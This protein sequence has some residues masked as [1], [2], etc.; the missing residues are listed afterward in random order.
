[1]KIT[2]LGIGFVLMSAP[3]FAAAQAGQLAH[4][5]EVRTRAAEAHA[6]ALKSGDRAAAVRAIA[7][8]RAADEAIYYDK[9]DAALAAEG[10]PKGDT[11]ASE[12]ALLN[13]KEAAQRAAES[14]DKAAIARADAELR[15][16]YHHDWEVRHPGKPRKG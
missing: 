15:E 1:M 9:Q 16:A 5:Q 13:A 6:Q 11:R 3:T 7:Q 4:D 14:G 8:I 12:M 2:L 10:P